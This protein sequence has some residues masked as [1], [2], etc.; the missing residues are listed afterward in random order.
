MRALLIRLAGV[1]A[2]F[3]D[4]RINTAKIGL[5]SRTLHCPPPCTVHGLLMAAKGGW[6]DPRVLRVGWRLDYESVGIDFQTSL[7]PQRSGYNW[8]SGVQKTKVSPVEREFLAFPVLSILGLSGVSPNWFRSPANPLSLGRSEDLI[9]EKVWQEIEVEPLQQGEIARQCLP[10]DLGSGTIYPAP[11]Y[12]DCNRRPVGM[13]P[14]IDAH[15]KQE[16]CLSS[17]D[18]I[19]AKVPKSGEIF[20][21]WNFGSSES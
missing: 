9:T 19:L 12:F 18:A 15:L 6:I 17:T 3:R 16:V 10:L 1:T 20:Y 8:T 4:P 21:V 2:H 7:L 5:P 13:A 14:R 11:L